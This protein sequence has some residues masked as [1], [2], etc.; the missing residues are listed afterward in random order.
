MQVTLILL[1]EQIVVALGGEFQLFLPQLVPHM[2]RVFMHDNSPGRAVTVRVGIVT[3][4]VSPSLI[5]HSTSLA[6]LLI[7]P[8]LHW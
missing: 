1:V 6:P 5:P 2:L 7:I 3:H 8:L 4:L